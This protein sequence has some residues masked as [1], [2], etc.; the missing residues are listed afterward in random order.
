[1][2][3]ERV[4]DAGGLKLTIKTDSEL[5]ETMGEARVT[6]GEITL[7]DRWLGDNRMLARV[8]IH[9]LLEIISLSVLCYSLKHDDIELIEGPL[10][11]ALLQLGWSPTL[12][13]VK[14]SIP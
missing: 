14:E 9:E 8:L 13:S 5:T 11:D 10:V 4:I 6:A 12:E 2:M 1:M 3:K 7:S